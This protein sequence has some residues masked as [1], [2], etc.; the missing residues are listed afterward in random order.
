MVRQIRF[1]EEKVLMGRYKGLLLAEVICI[2]CSMSACQRTVKDETRTTDS[3]ISENADEHMD[4]T[5]S[6]VKSEGL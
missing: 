6:E 4:E 2:A 3:I 1:G 5:N